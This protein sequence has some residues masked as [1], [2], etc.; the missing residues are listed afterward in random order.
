MII[1]EHSRVEEVF[2]LTWMK[3]LRSLSINGAL[4]SKKG[5]LHGQCAL[6]SPSILVSVVMLVLK[7]V[8]RNFQ[9]IPE[10][11]VRVY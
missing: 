2:R 5:E 6:L 4:F 9:N 10:H 1:P 3:H 11:F 7:I 8:F